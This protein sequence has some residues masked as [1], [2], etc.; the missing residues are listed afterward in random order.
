MGRHSA[1]RGWCLALVALGALLVSAVR[2]AGDQATV[3]GAAAAPRTAAQSSVA[4]AAASNV[5]FASVSTS[6]GVSYDT[7]EQA[8]AGC[9]M[10][11]PAGC[12]TKGCRARGCL[13]CSGAVCHCCA[14]GYRL[15]AD[16]R[17]CIP[18]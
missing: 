18:W 3:A 11:L 12:R 14:K 8:S 6:G 15:A 16:K 4:T 13:A 7:V 5:S 10:R 2:A 1:V 9:G 17:S